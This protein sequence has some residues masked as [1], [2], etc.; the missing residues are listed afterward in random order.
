MMS[1]SLLVLDYWTHMPSDSLQPKQAVSPSPAPPPPQQARNIVTSSRLCRKNQDLPIHKIKSKARHKEYLKCHKLGC[2]VNNNAKD[3]NGHL[4]FA[5]IKLH[6]VPKYQTELKAKKP[7]IRLLST[8]KS[9]SF[10]GEKSCNKWGWT[11]M[12]TDKSI[13]FVSTTSFFTKLILWK[14][15][16]ERKVVSKV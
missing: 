3:K 5:H 9:K 12:T 15:N 16:M 13:G 4:L 8:G 14:S 1:A 11:K 10:S 7:K 2:L 6:K